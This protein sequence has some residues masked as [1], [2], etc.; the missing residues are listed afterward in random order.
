MRGRTNITQRSGTVPVNGDIKEFEVAEGNEINV[1][2]F[3]SYKTVENVSKLFDAY[4]E[5]TF[6]EYLGN[7]YYAFILNN[8]L[9]LLKYENST[10]NV[11]YIYNDY[12][13]KAFSVLQDGSLICC[14]ENS[15][16][17]IRLGFNG[18]EL[19]FLNSAGSDASGVNSPNYCFVYENNFCV[20][21]SGSS[22]VYSYFYKLDESFN[23]NYISYTSSNLEYSRISRGIC[24]FANIG[25]DV[26][27]MWAGGTSSTA[28]QYWFLNKLSVDFENNTSSTE[29]IYTN[30]IDYKKYKRNFLTP[31]LFNDKYYVIIYEPESSTSGYNE[32]T[33]ILIYNINSNTKTEQLLKNLGF[34]YT[35]GGLIGIQSKIFDNNKFALL[36]DMQVAILEFNEDVSEVNLISNILTIDV[37][38]SIG[39][40]LKN[41]LSFSL[42]MPGSSGTISQEV[43][44]N[45]SY[46]FLS[47]FLDKSFVTSYD[48]SSLS[49]G[50][51]KTSGNPGD[52]IQVYVPKSN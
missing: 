51:A 13:I 42:I 15:P 49:I 46:N 2:D 20:I 41:D 29:S 24:N 17:V 45:E 43:N 27:F 18:N 50:F 21:Y 28:Q 23:I 38:N 4:G 9:Y 8:S 10:V 22:T 36:F 26:Y 52:I 7:N 16:Y 1:G 31:L 32:E 6:W 5:I 48:G 47:Q 34:N 33:K 25:K 44:C 3:V 19:I 30:I 40:I 39:I 14:V 12:I 35:S 37:R 11:V